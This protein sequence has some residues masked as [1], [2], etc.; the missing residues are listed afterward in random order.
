M[1]KPV[2]IITGA[3]GN[4]G[5]ATVRQFIEEGYHVVATVSSGNSLGY[6]QDHPSLTVFPVNVLDADQSAQL[7]KEVTL[8][9]GEI[10]SVFML[11]G[12]YISG[13]FEETGLD[14]LDKMINM[15]FKSA[16]T[17]AQPAFR[18]MMKQKSGGRLVFIGARPAIQPEEARTAVAYALSK[19]LL[20]RLAESINA[21][22][23]GRNIT[24]HVIIPSIIDTE[25][26]RASQPEADYSNWVKP[27]ELADVMLYTASGKGAALRETVLKVYG[28]A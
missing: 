20:F 1:S 24:A 5:K 14:A 15:N 22:S 19:S 10:H 26:N 16:Y 21:E 7:V 3:K 6:L 8:R 23:R 17:I 11:V 27:E 25:V 4:L 2:V 13:T 12:T 18:Q 28:N 9:F